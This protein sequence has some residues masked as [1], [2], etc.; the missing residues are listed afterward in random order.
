MAFVNVPRRAGARARIKIKPCRRHTLI[1][2]YYKSLLQLLVGSSLPLLNPPYIQLKKQSP[3]AKTTST[4][5]PLHRIKQPD[6][7]LRQRWYLPIEGL[8]IRHIALLF[9]LN[10]LLDQFMQL[11]MG[12]LQLHHLRDMAKVL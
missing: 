2:R 6:N 9:K 1:I 11:L 3:Q 4:N 10:D 12:R 7:F 5:L 8:G